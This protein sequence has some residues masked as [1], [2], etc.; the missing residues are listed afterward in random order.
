MLIGHKQNFSINYIRSAI[1]FSKKLLE[2]ENIKVNPLLEEEKLEYLSYCY[3]AILLSA[4]FLEATINELFV[5]ISER[6]EWAVASMPSEVVDIRFHKLV[7]DLWEEGIPRTASYSIIKKYQIALKLA[8]KEIINDKVILQNAEDLVKLRNQLVHAESEWIY[9]DPT[10]N[11]KNKSLKLGKHLESK[12][13][14]SP[15][16]G[17]GGQFFPYRCFGH[18]CTKWAIISAIAFSDEFFKKMGLT[19]KYHY[20]KD[21]YLNF[22]KI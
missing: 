11:K 14:Q 16:F 13:E 9:N 4:A 21:E 10:M 2:F 18:G 17:N 20:M 15:F 8:E 5:D 7:K 6:Q 22:D 12:F 3:S 1:F 19:P